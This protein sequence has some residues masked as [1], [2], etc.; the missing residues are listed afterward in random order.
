MGLHIDASSGFEVTRLI[1]AGI[2]AN[3]ISMSTQEFP[4]DFST[5]YKKGILFNASSLLQLERFGKLFPGHSCGIRFIPGMGSGGT[6]YK[7]NVGGASSSFGIWYQLLPQVLEIVEKYNIKIVRLHTHIGSGSDPAVW[8]KISGDSL[9]L[10]HS[11]PDAETLNLGGGYKVGRLSR[12][13][14]SSTDLQKIGIP[15]SHEFEN[16]AQLTGRK[17]KLEIEPGTFLLANSGALLCEVQDMV[18]TGKD[19]YNFLKLDS[20]MTDLLRPSLY[21]AQH[22]MS[23]I[24]SESEKETRKKTKYVVVGHCCESGD[25]FTPAPGDAESLSQRPLLE[26]KTGD[27]MVIDGSGAYSSSM[28]TKNYNSFPECPELMKAV[29]GTVRVIRKRQ[30]IDQML[31]NECP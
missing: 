14:H 11:F 13:K 25:L 4:E 20:G 23:I 12:E 16:F 10:M 24:T 9:N 27:M 1:R 18:T 3:H 2:P 19:G 22:P 26:A 8:Q 21:G 31:A 17:L 28:C 5:L 7:T 6:A 29:D 30:T 15:V